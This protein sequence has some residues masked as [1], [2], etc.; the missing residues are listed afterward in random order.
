[1]TDR[2]TDIPTC[3]MSKTVSAQANTGC[4][5]RT[6]Q[7]SPP[8]SP[9]TLVFLHEISYHRSQ[10]KPLAMASNKTGMGKDSEKT[11]FRPIRRYISKTITDNI[12]D[13]EVENDV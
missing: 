11:D 4:N 3:S 5:C 10:G 12:D 7:S 2:S 8:G 1:M 9:E 6:L 13:N